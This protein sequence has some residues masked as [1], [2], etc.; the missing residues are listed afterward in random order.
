MIFSLKLIPIVKIDGLD[1]FNRF[2]RLI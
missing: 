1:R 2:D